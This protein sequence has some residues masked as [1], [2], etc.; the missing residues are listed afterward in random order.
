VNIKIP[1]LAETIVIREDA[2]IDRLASAMVHKMEIAMA[3][4]AGA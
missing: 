4:Y 3:D 1:K 2:D